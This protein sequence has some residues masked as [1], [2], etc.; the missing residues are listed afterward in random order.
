MLEARSVAVVG[1]SARPGSLGERLLIEL[2]RS[3]G[4]PTIHLV[5][6]RYDKIG[7]RACLPSLGAIPDPVDLVAIAV[8]DHAVE[9]QLSLAASLHP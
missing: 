7:S 2:E 1:A 4:R 3:P 9:E 8:G 6:P 5:N